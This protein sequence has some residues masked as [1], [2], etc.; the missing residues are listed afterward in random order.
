MEAIRGRVNQ[1]P[2]EREKRQKQLALP[3]IVSLALSIAMLVIGLQV[4]LN[5]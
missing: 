2:E 5:Y 3:N 1:T 4:G